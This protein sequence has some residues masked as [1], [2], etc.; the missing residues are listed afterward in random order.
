MKRREALSLLAVGLS[1]CAIRRSAGRVGTVPERKMET[2]TYKAVGNVRI[3][4]DAYG[5]ASGGPPR[6][7][8]MTIHGGAL[9]M[10]AR[11][12]IQ[13][14]LFE[15]LL[16]RGFVIVS[17]DYRLAPETKLP[18]IIKDVEDAYQSAFERIAVVIASVA[19]AANAEGRTLARA[20]Q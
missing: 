15:P 4:A 13:M 17:I 9:I 6:P 7:V 16:E 11:Y 18:E 12:P 10:G 19:H 14:D 8:I 1:G 5:A 20:R 2:Y 3:K